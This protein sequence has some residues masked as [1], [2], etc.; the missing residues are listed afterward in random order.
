SHQDTYYSDCVGG[1]KYFEDCEIHGT[2]DF[3]CGDGS[4]YFKN[5]LL[6]CERRGSNG[7][8]VDIIT[9]NRASAEDRGYIFEGCTIKSEWPVVSLGRAWREQPRCVFLN[10]VFDYGAGEFAVTSNKIQRWN[11]EG[12]RVLPELFGEYK[13][14]DVQGRVISPKTNNVTFTFRDTSKTMNTI[15]S[16]KQAKKYSLKAVFGP[17]ANEIKQTILTNQIYKQ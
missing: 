9:A 11:I 16:A 17:W 5:C 2:V 8:G 10:T 15:L 12:M 6:Y 4:V 1:L 3:I 7:G 13:T 14:K